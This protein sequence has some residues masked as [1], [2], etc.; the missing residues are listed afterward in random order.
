MMAFANAN[1]G[2]WTLPVFRIPMEDNIKR[3]ISFLIEILKGHVIKVFKKLQAS[4]EVDI[5]KIN[6]SNKQP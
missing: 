4:Y 5:K 3:N 2:P 6:I 1:F